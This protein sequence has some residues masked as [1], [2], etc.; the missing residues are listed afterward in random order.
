ME[1]PEVGY[2]E[3]CISPEAY[4]LIN[5]L[6]NPNWKERLGANGAEEIK[7][8]PFFKDVDFQKIRTSGAPILPKMIVPEEDME[9]REKDKARFQNFLKDLNMNKMK[10]K[11]EE[12]ISEILEKELKTLERM[13]LLKEMSIEAGRKQMEIYEKQIAEQK[14]KVDIFQKN[15]KFIQRKIQDDN[16]SS[17]SVCSLSVINENNQEEFQCNQ[18]YTFLE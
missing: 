12:N 16:L 1:W 6:L 4:E 2:E 7:Q 18:S 13:D 5:K 9:K 8:D 10:K 17:N 11:G 14:K 15:L 3:D